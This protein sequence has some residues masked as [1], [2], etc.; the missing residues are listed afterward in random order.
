MADISHSRI[1]QAL[2]K[3]NKR[4]AMTG[5]FLAAGFVGALGLPDYDPINSSFFSR[6]FDWPGIRER[7]GRCHCWAGD[8]DRYVPLSRSQELAE[9][10]DA[11]L[12]V[13]A[14]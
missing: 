11:P 12:E 13:V 4:V 2:A 10:L 1:D 14:T 6:P 3:R 7:M 9:R 8:D 5:L